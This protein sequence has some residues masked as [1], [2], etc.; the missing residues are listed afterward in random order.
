M[1]TLTQHLAPTTRLY[2]SVDLDFWN[3]RSLAECRKVLDY[4]KFRHKKI[5]IVDEHQDLLPDINRHE[6][7][8][9]INLDYHSDISNNEAVE[10]SC[11]QEW[12]DKD[13][14]YK[15]PLNCGTWANWVREASRQHFLWLYPSGVKMSNALC[16]EPKEPKYNPFR[17]PSVAGWERVTK[18]AVSKFPYYLIDNAIGVGLSLSKEWLNFG[19]DESLLGI[20][21]DLFGEKRIEKVLDV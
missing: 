9:V 6:P 4:I 17:R 8:T 13:Q 10:W 12:D 15:A 7:D 3:E 11:N 2:L 16:H 1:S 20:V 19:K 14:D 18:K 5:E 21:K